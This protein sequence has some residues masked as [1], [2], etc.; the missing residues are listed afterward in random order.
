MNGMSIPPNTSIADG[1]RHL[2][3]DGFC[4]SIFVTSEEQELLGVVSHID[5]IAY[6]LNGTSAAEDEAMST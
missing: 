3:E 4:E 1:I 5:I 6:L 2:V